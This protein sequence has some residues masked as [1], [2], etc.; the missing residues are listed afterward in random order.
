MDKVEIG[1]HSNPKYSKIVRCAV[2]HLCDLGGLSA[3]AANTIT[4][5][6][7]EALTNIMRHAYG[8]ATDESIRIECRLLEDRLEF[9]LRDRG[10]QVDPAS[11]QSRDLA[12]V[13]PGGLGVHLIR[14]TM[15]EVTY[16]HHPDGG[17]ELR[18][19]KYLPGE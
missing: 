11:I 6:V 5:A 12:D 17:N 4:L 18:L 13:R 2:T 8:G 3:A 10:A 14:S 16:Q 9:V 19:V 15:D 1:I 7:D